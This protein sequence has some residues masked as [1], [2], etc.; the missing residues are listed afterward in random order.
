MSPMRTTKSVWCKDRDR[1]GMIL[2]VV[3]VLLLGVVADAK[4][5]E[6]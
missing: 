2:R 1:V 5:Y 6:E 3:V 4:Y